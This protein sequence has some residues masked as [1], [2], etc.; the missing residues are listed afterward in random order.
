MQM[1]KCVILNSYF[2]RIDHLHFRFSPKILRAIGE[3]Q[4]GTLCSNFLLGL[5]TSNKVHCQL[6]HII[7]E[8]N[9]NTQ[10][11]ILNVSLFKI[12]ISKLGE[13]CVKSN[14]GIA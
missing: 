2:C 10:L 6:Y 1:N 13:G 9:K 7:Y 12:I 11:V 3:K 4:Y 5:A 14:E 8:V